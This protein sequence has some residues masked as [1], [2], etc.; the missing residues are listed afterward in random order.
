MIFACHCLLNEM[1]GPDSFCPCHGREGK[2]RLE[3]RRGKGS[4]ISMASEFGQRMPTRDGNM[5]RLKEIM[6]EMCVLLEKLGA[7]GAPG[8]RRSAML[9]EDAYVLLADAAALYRRAHSGE[10][11]VAEACTATQ[12]KLI[13]LEESLVEESAFHSATWE[14]HTR[15]GIRELTPV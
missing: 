9:V 2:G 3:V 7:S 14:K 10:S 1:H 11:P 4:K 12:L 15:E 5:A 6:A 13:G 8:D